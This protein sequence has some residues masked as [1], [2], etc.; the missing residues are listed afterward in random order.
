MVE[1]AYFGGAPNSLILRDGAGI[2]AKIDA[3]TRA[4]SRNLH[5][6]GQRVRW[7]PPDST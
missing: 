1:W 6:V 5:L 7:L 2:I 4:H 3:K